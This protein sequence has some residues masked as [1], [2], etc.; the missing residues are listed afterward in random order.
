MY[1]ILFWKS[2][3]LLK[4]AKTFSLLQKDRILGFIGFR[5]VEII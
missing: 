5:N 2:G 1:T 4:R 3:I